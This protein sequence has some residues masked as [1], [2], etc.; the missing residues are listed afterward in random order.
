MAWEVGINQKGDGTRISALMENTICSAPRSE[1]NILRGR[2]YGD[3]WPLLTVQ[4]INS[5]YKKTF[6]PTKPTMTNLLE[7][8]TLH[9]ISVI[10]ASPNP[11]DIFRMLHHY[12]TDVVPE[13][14]YGP[15]GN[16]NLPCPNV[17]L[18]NSFKFTLPLS[19]LSGTSY[20]I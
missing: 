6:L 14:T 9:L 2:N 18:I 3:Q 15:K 8:H 16:T 17:V 13:F 19:K 5:M 1:S 7:S 11:V 10:A 4:V 20:Q 12:A